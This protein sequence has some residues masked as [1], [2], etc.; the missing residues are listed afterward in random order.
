MKKYKLIRQ[1]IFFS[2]NEIISDEKNKVYS[3]IIEANDCI[4][5]YDEVILTNKE[6]AEKFGYKL[7][8]KLKTLKSITFFK[9]N[10][11]ETIE[12]MIGDPFYKVLDENDNIIFKHKCHS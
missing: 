7:N 3:T 11:E 12:L 9:D 5:N 6:L 2:S 4:E 1:K 8:D 10:E